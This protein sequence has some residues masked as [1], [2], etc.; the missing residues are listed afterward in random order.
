MQ[1]YGLN[2]ILTHRDFVYTDGRSRKLPGRSSGMRNNSVSVSTV[3]V[4]VTHCSLA[5]YAY[6]LRRRSPENKLI[7]D[8]DDETRKAVVINLFRGGGYF[9]AFVSSLSFPLSSFPFPLSFSLLEVAPLIQLR[10]LGSV[11]SSLSTGE[12]DSCSRQRRSMS[13]MSV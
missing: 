13:S 3:V 2:E 7:A 9:F 1:L 11:V 5:L 10:D 8:A 4:I 12:N 6:T